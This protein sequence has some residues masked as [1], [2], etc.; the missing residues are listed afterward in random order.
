MMERWNTGMMEYW[1]ELILVSFLLTH[2]S[3]VPIIHYS[4]I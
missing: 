1:E 2:Y 4:V 3:I